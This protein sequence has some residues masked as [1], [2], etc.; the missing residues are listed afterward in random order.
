MKQKL[1][2]KYKKLEEKLVK[3]YIAAQTAVCILWL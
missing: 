2:E 3:L 1:K